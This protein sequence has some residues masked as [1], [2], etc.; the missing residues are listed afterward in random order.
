MMHRML[1]VARPR[2]AALAS[3][4]AARPLSSVPPKTM[5]LEQALTSTH[6]M[7]QEIESPAA[8]QQM[9]SLRGSGDMMAKWQTA[10]AVLVHATLRTLPQ[11]GYTADGAGL[12]QY[13]QAFAD[14]MNTGSAEVKAT[15][16]GLNESKW[17]VLLKHTFDCAPAPAIDLAKAVRFLLVSIARSWS[18]PAHGPAHPAL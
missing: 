8:V 1:F 5:T 13:T 2:V 3:L 16:R 7:I 10:N 17:A 15:L 6:L 14:C 4:R 18:G 12:Q 9:E 11:I